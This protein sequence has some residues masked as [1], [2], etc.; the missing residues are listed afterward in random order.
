MSAPAENTRA[1]RNVS[2]TASQPLT[3]N[4]AFT[5]TGCA[6]CPTHRAL[7]DVWVLLQPESVEITHWSADRYSDQLSKEYRNP[8]VALPTP[9][10]P[11]IRNERE[12][13]GHPL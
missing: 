5:L 9:Q 13:A 1:S 4:P 10:H 7:C 6:G 2:S 11:H 3:E 12:C 8:T